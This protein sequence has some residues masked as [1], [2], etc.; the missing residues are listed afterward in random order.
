ML[1]LEDVFS[2]TA[3]RK[4]VDGALAGSVREPRLVWWISIR[5]STLGDIEKG[6]GLLCLAVPFI[7]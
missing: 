4:E 3:Q 2:V 6:P 1:D 5:R 7:F